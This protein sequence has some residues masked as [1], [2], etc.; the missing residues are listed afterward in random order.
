MICKRIKPSPFVSQFIKEY[1]LVHLIFNEQEIAPV[2]AYPI[3]PKEGITFQFRGYLI[4]ETPT[5]NFTEKRPKVNIFSISPARQNFY[6][7]HEFMFVNVE[8]QSGALAQFLK[9]PMTELTTGSL[10]AS[11]IFGKE[12]EEVNDRLANTAAYDEIPIVLDNYFLNKIKQIKQN[13]LPIDKIGYL[14]VNNP[15]NFNLDKMAK[16]ACMSHRTFE[17]R[18]LQKVGVTPKYFARICRFYQAYEQK[19]LSPKLDWFS[20]A[21]QNGYTDYQ[22]LVKDFKQF[23]GVT[24]NIFMQHSN[25]NPEK[26]LID[27]NPNFIGV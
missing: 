14:I 20:I 19:E 8:F 5:L 4:A 26:R 3:N 10:D 27:I 18:F 12:I 7:T 6:Q 17:N 23:A 1:L 2:K 9:I 22:H 24:P 21:V 25:Q 13:F 16:S 15:S 11:L